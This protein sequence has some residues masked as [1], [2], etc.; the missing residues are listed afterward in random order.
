MAKALA[1]RNGPSVAE[2]AQL[3]LQNKIRVWRKNDGWANPYKLITHNN[4]GNACIINV[5][6]KPTNFRIISIRF[7]HRNE[8]TTKITPKNISDN[9]HNTNDEYHTKSAEPIALKRKRERPSG[10]K[11]N[12]KIA[13]TNTTNV[14][15]TQKKRNN[16][17]LAVKLRQKSKIITPGKPFELLN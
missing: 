2:V 14:F 3:P 11:N 4:S 17:K 15:I 12:P 9:S 16:A 5:N 13:I 6:G 7:Y 8:Y 10:S 1:T